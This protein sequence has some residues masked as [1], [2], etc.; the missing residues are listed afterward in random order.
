MSVVL[1]RPA[2]RNPEAVEPRSRFRRFIAEFP[3][4][5]M[6]TIPTHV[7]IMLALALIALMVH[8]LN[9][10][11]YPAVGDDEGTYLAQAWAVQQGEGL[12]PYTYWY[13]HPPL[14]WLQIAAF[15]WIPATFVPGP[16]AV[17]NARVL[18]LPVT[19]ISVCLLYTLGRRLKLPLWAA[20]L[21]SLLFAL[22]P[23]AV[24]LQRQ[25]YLDNIAVVWILGAFV[26]A[27]SPKRHLWH[28]VA[29]GCC[30]AVAILSKETM[31]V[32]L[33]ALFLALWQGSHPSTRKFSIVGF[34]TLLGLVGVLYPLYALLNNELLPGPGHVSLV[35]GILFQLQRA[36]SGSLFDPTSASRAIL[37]SWLY[38]DKVVP[39]AGAVA[40]LIAMITLRTLRAPALAVLLLVGMVMRPGYLPAMYVIQALPFLSLCIAGVLA[41]AVGV[42]LQKGPLRDGAW[43][44]VRIGVV[45][46]GMTGLLVSVVPAWVGGDTV[47]IT[48]QSNTEFREV[49]DALNVLPHNK[50]TK[51]LVDDG[52]WLDLVRAGYQPG[53]GAIWFYKLDL[54]PA[55]KLANGWHDL[56]YV[57]A[58]PIIRESMTGL[59][60]VTEAMKNSTVVR[61]FGTG[62]E[63]I[64]IRSV[65][66]GR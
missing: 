38:Y 17:A 33:P 8:G 28:H 54:D 60:T 32:V 18:M 39:I 20:A 40:G 10:A 2:D 51:V 30:A 9:I 11:G 19:V 53:Q 43:R 52:I 48:R 16:L 46:V 24:T 34:L 41:A 3:T 45:A 31:L 62:D 64:E 26:L 44:W 14:G 56:D 47:A 57:V 29:A 1:E 65:K 6:P 15:S 27:L 42:V 7:W 59:P 5:R 36:G 49:V 61:T 63:R 25:I 55:V 21:G 66:E 50:D 4:P 13:D 12:A 58:S 22:S 37:H 23:L 35:G